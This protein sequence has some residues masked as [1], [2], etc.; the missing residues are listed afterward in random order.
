MFKYIS[1][2]LAVVILCA[3]SSCGGSDSKTEQPSLDGSH[4]VGMGGSYETPRY[5]S[6]S[7]VAPSFSGAQAAPSVTS[8]FAAPGASA[9]ED[10]DN[11]VKQFCDVSTA[12]DAYMA[13]FNSVG[14][15][16]V[17]MQKQAEEWKAKAS[18]DADYSCHLARALQCLTPLM[19]R[20]LRGNEAEFADL[21]HEA[22]ACVA[23]LPSE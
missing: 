19:H 22:Q 6:Q 2:M 16:S 4:T 21:S 18:V 23:G 5:S 20:S 12:V 11:R 7:Q 1:L 3:V 14:E 8:S 17:S 9:R 10:G 13:E 15:L